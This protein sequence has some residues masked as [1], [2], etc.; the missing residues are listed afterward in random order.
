M[1]TTLLPVLALFASA[2]LTV[3][4]RQTPQAYLEKGNNL[5]RSGKYEEA[6]LNY[7][8]AIQKDARFGEAYYRIGIAQLR[9]GNNSDAYR[10]LFSANTLLP[11][12]T[13]VKVTLAELTLLAFLSNPSRPA[14]YYKQ[15][16]QLSGE[17]LAR[18]PNSYDGLWIKGNLAWT[19]RHLKEAEEFFGKANAVKS[20]QPEL[21]AAWT[22]VLLQDGR[23]EDGERLAL[24][25]LQTHK[26][27][28]K[29]YDV[30]YRYYRSQNR[31]A[32][33][34]N[35][36]RTKVNNNPSEIDYSLQLASFYAAAGRRDEMTATLQ[37]VLDDP[38]TFPDARLK[39][40]DFY[41]SIHDVPEAL[42]RYEEGAKANPKEQRIYLKRIADAWM[43]QGKADKAS[44]VLGEILKERPNDETAKAVNASLLV[45]T[46]K[47]DKMEAGLK[48]YQD[49]VDKDPG[50]PLLRFGMGQALMA[51]GDLDRARGQFQESLRRRPHFLPSL[52]ALAEVSQRKRDFAQMLQYANEALAVNPRF[53]RARILRATAL[54]ATQKYV[55][56]RSEL[57]SLEQDFPQNLDVQVLIAGLDFAAKKYGE[58]ETRLL[59]VFEKDKLVALADLVEVYGAEKRPDKALS[60]LT[61]EL[62]K[63]PDSVA[64]RTLL[65]DTAL[66]SAK[67]DM[68]LEQYKRLQAQGVRSAQLQMRLGN[69]YE[70]KGDFKNALASYEAAQNLAPGDPAVSAGLADALRLLGR[71]QE[72]IANYRSLLT[73]EPDNAIALNNLAYLLIDDPQ[74]LDEAQ[75]LVEHALRVAPRNPDFADTQG[76]VYLKKNLGDR[77]TRVFSELVRKYPGNVQYRY[78]HGLSLLQTGQR[79]KAKVEMEAA[80]RKAPDGDLRKVIQ[81]SLAEASK[82]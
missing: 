81:T 32:D 65:G 34:E 9:K 68:A 4:C 33:A 52:V 35:I 2:S 47:P 36:L 37:R 49:L 57:A 82:P 6:I 74:K 46:G 7:Q 66:R 26:D 78:H 15:L 79:V 62:S 73:R 13:D 67:Y 28:G 41:S 53:T 80:L 10:S 72:A 3:S 69:A 71:N 44:E 43:M 40:G 1:K 38:K 75:R 22:S 20:S 23:V 39:V 58:A 76:M 50:N 18:D 5:Y 25:C 77:A 30:L 11:D 55:E 60:L 12:R 17:L 45:K 56:A 19:D 51:K 27:A 54:V 21:I 42:R 31:I 8:K 16:I 29:V 63:S 61:V 48:D 24:E 64:V 14:V 70:L 59:K